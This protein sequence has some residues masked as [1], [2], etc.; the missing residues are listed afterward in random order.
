M[1]SFFSDRDFMKVM[2]SEVWLLIRRL[3]PIS[4]CLLPA[5]A[6]TVDCVGRKK[7]CSGIE[8]PRATRRRGNMSEGH[9]C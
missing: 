3:C 6:V 4:R 8:H 5:E 7:S 1:T 2:A 9:N